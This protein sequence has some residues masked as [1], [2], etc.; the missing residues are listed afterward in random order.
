MITKRYD[1]TICSR[2][3]LKGERKYSTPDGNKLTSVT[4]ILN[5]TKSEEAKKSL[6]DWQKRV[7]Y[8]KAKEISVTAANRGTR[9]HSFL[10]HYIKDDV[11]KEPGTNPFSIQSHKMAKLIIDNAFPNIDES[12]G[13]EVSLY[14][15]E[16]YAGA[17]DYA[18]TWK[19]KP[20]I[21][22]FK[23]SNKLKIKSWIE[24]YFL[25]SCAYALCHNVLY[26]T[27]INTG[28]ILICTSD[29]QYQE[30]IIE[31]DEFFH[32]CQKWWD[33]VEEYYKIQK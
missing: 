31:G 7:G 12:W 8:E 6:L 2:E 20:A 28:V 3:N 24:D 19:G 13:V 15:P 26:N 33:R 17:T 14:Y 4:T 25:Q 1:Y 5:A 22:D 10:E 21:I 27:N 16:L 18:A 30:F 11:L 29:Y 32:Y 23:Q 9:M